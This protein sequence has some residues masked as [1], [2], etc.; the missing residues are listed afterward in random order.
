MK[1]KKDEVW[2]NGHYYHTTIVVNGKKIKVR[3][4]KNGFKRK[5]TK[6]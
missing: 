2:V 6:K 4:W 5:S 1:K 3:R